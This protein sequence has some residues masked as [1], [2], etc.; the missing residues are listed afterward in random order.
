MSKKIHKKDLQ[1]GK[2]DE[3]RSVLDA[4]GEAAVVQAPDPLTV[5]QE[6][7]RLAEAGAKTDAPASNAKPETGLNPEQ[8]ADSKKAEASQS[9]QVRNATRPLA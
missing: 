6:S 9:G 5:K 3:T 2:T 1:P 4:E 7:A 8:K